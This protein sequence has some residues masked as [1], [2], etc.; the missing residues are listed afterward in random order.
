MSRKYYINE[1]PSSVNFIADMA[2]VMYIHVACWISFKSISLNSNDYIDVCCRNIPNVA[3]NSHYEI[4]E[5]VISIVLDVVPHTSKLT[6]PVEINLPVNQNSTP[7][8]NYSFPEGT[9]L[10]VNPSC[11]FWSSHNL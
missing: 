6:T 1:Y 3:K 4:G 7:R 2:G 9:D 11:V 10:N 5:V 8:L